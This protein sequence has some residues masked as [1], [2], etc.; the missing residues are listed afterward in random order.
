MEIKNEEIGDQFKISDKET[1]LLP[2]AN[3][4]I[5]AL[6]QPTGT[7]LSVIKDRLKESCSKI[8]ADFHEINLTELL[9]DLSDIFLNST[10]MQPKIAKFAKDEE[11]ASDSFRDLSMKMHKGTILRETTR[12]DI[13]AIYG[14]ARIY[15]VRQQLYRNMN[16]LKK[17]VFLLNSLKHPDESKLLRCLCPKSILI[18]S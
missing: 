18:R 3:E 1:N 16:A 13:F 17:R 15:E 12:N 11:K 8:N 9:T 5:L 6:V 10:I 7:N 2:Q 14:L 4:V